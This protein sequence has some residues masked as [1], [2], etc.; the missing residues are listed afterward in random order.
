MKYTFIFILILTLFS[1][2]KDDEEPSV[3]EQ[4]NDKGIIL[5]IS[6][7]GSLQNPAFSPDD[8]SIVFTRFVK[9]YNTEPAEIYKFDLTT[10]KLT[11]MISEGSGNINLPGSCWK[12]GNIV[13]ASTRDPHDEIYMI[14]ENG[15]SGDEIQI[16]NRTSK[17]A[18]E[19]SFSPDGDWIVFESHKLDVEDD[20]IITKYKVDG[21]SSYIE[22]SNLGDDCRQP[23]WSPSNNKILYQ[24]KL[25]GQWNI[26]IMDIDGANKTQLTSNLG[27]CTDASFSADGQYVVFSS[28]YNVKIAN[29]YKISIDGTNPIK[30]TSYDGYDGAPSISNDAKKLVFESTNGDPD[31]SAGT[32][33]VMLNL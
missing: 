22:L 13:F 5:N 4:R 19:P 6:L 11:L 2:D 12:N 27:N 8:N 15:K 29:I 25:N 28:D 24:R 26:W 23:N 32:K 21:T 20:G 18:Y 14:S 1:C 3:S 7:S 30:L 9:G 33:I 17:V 16:T 10:K 31:E